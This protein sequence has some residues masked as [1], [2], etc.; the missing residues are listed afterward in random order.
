MS[1]TYKY[2]NSVNIP[3][4]QFLLMLFIMRVHTLVLGGRR[5]VTTKSIHFCGGERTSCSL[6][7]IDR[8]YGQDGAQS[9]QSQTYRLQTVNTNNILEC[10]TD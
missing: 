3:K 2:R 8:G 10:H 6:C 4:H 9:E 1:S 5:S 7:G